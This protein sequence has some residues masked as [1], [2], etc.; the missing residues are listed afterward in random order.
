LAVYHKQTAP[1][2]EYYQGKGL[3]KTVSGEQGMDETYADILKVLGV[4]S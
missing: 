2:V 3:L 1:L 4:K